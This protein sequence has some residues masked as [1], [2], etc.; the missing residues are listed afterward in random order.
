MTF[1]RWWSDSLYRNSAALIVNTG[2]SAILGFGYWLAAARVLSPSE[3]G[4]GAVAVTGTM[5]AANFGWAGI[6]FVVLRYLPAAGRSSARLS[7]GSYLVAVALAALASMALLLF[8]GGDSSVAM[9][10]EHPL[11]PPAMVAAAGLW[12]VFS[13]QDAALTGLRQS[14]WIP[15]EN[16]L[17]GLA[18]LGLLLILAPMVGWVS[19]PI[20]WFAPTMVLVPLVSAL[21]VRRVRW[22]TDEPSLPT[23]ARMTE[24]AAGQH[25]IAMAVSVPELLLPVV[26]LTL[27]G[28]EASAFYITAWTVAFSIRLIALN[29]V[30]AFTVEGAHRGEEGQLLRQAALLLGGIIVPVLLVVFLTSEVVMGL[31]GSSY[32]RESADLLK[33][34]AV[35]LL[36]YSVTTF[37]LALERIRSRVSRA[38]AVT[39]TSAVTILALTVWLVPSVGILGAGI[40]FVV[41]NLVGAAASLGLMLGNRALERSDFA[42]TD[43]RL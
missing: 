6:Q 37:F 12:V 33:L 34:F 15:A 9:I 29:V 30:N 40:A 39:F 16:T 14:P 23:L 19:L 10:I 3:L 1:R 42:A 26:V 20:S 38:V 32:S 2:L 31:F 4:I 27:A 36:P 22:D 41:G 25:V 13:L 5:L 21:V 28:S 8:F 18:K 35:G 11:A 24:F 43:H 17:Y 7:A